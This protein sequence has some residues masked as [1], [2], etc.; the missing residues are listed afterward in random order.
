NEEEGRL[1][2]R[3]A[4]LLTAACWFAVGL[5]MA[6]TWQPA[7]ILSIEA[8]L[9]AAL[10]ILALRRSPRFTLLPLAALW[11]AAGFWCWQLRPVPSQ[12]HALTQ[13]ADGLSRNVRGH[14]VR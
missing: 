8:I 14:V 12:Q 7:F 3:R 11:I 1:R 13:Y 5:A 4:P 6:R 9:L 2:F 10:V